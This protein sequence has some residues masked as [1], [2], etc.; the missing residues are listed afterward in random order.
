MHNYQNRAEC[1]GTVFLFA[2]TLEPLYHAK[3]IRMNA[4]VNKEELFFT[5]NGKGN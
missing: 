4:H 1:L 3:L 2:G 5:W